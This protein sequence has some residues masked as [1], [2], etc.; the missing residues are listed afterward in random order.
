MYNMDQMTNNIAIPKHTL[1]NPSNLAT[2]RTTITEE[3]RAGES[4]GENG[5]GG[6]ERAHDSGSNYNPGTLRPNNNFDENR[7]DGMNLYDEEESG[8]NEN[9]Y[10]NYL[11]SNGGE[12]SG[13]RGLGKEIGQN[14]Q[15][16][17]EARDET[18]MN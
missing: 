13:K 1:P 7:R 3:D 6:E 9:S 12:V 18:G 11:G 8:M 2:S 4:Y 5:R 17:S 15:T 14:G 16:D 10:K